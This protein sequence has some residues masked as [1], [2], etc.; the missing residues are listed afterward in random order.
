MNKKIILKIVVIAII[1]LA[2]FA[3]SKYYKAD[4]CSKNDEGTCSLDLNIT[5]DN[6]ADQ[7]A[8]LNTDNEDLSSVEGSIKQKAKEVFTA[9]QN[10]DVESLTSLVHADMGVRFSPYGYISYDNDKQFFVDDLE[11]VFES[12]E[13]Y[14]WGTYHG[15][16]DPIEKTFDEFISEFFTD[17][18]F[19]EA[20]QIVYDERAGTGNSYS[21]VEQIYPNSHFVEFHF[22]GFN[23]EYQGMDWR[24]IRVVFAQDYDTEEWVVVGLISDQWTI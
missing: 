13:V 1:I 21:N 18:N 11:G 24:S 12:S 9:L 23:E 8:G 22:T 3:F 6:E 19:L 10:K 20:D 15:S 2:G 7:D 16:G 4:D 17:H 5:N 14:T